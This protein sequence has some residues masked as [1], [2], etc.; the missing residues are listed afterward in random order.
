MTETRSALLVANAIY[1]DTALRQLRS[2]VTDAQALARVLADPD[3]GNCQTR[4]L[5]D[6]PSYE[7]AEE[8][9]TFYSDRK[10][11]E[12]LIL[13]FSCHGLKDESGRLYFAAS[14]T[15][16]THLMAT[17]LSSAFVHEQ[18]ERS[19][20]RRL[21]LLLDCCYSGAFGRLSTKSDRRVE[22]TERFGGYG[23]VIITASSAMEYAFENA[24]LAMEASE[25]SVFTN[26]MVRGLSTG[27]ADVDGDGHVSVDDLYNYVY[28]E[29]RRTTPNQTP[30]MVSNVQGELYIASS[31][32]GPI[33]ALTPTTD[34]SDQPRHRP[35]PRQ[36][37]RQLG[38]RI[39]QRWA[40]VHPSH[41]WLLLDLC[42]VLALAIGI[43]VL[44]SELHG[45]WVELPDLPTALEGAGV[46]S[47]HGRVWV[48][49]G[50]SP[51]EDRPLLSTV[52]VY[53]P[54]TKRWSIGPKLPR[55]VA[56]GALVAVRD[57]LYLI[58]GQGD[59]GAVAN[60]F[61]LDNPTGTWIEDVALPQPREAGSG[62]WDGSRII[63]AGGVGRDHLAKRDVFAYQDNR[64]QL[65]GELQLAR[66][67]TSAATDGFGTVWIIGGR[68]MRGPTPAYSVIDVI[69]AEQVR[70]GGQVQP[71]HSAAAVYWPGAGV[72]VVGGQ[73]PEGFTGEVQ[74][75]THGTNLPPLS[76]PRA[77]LGAAVLGPDVYVVGGYDA[78]HH[79]S[80][81][82]EMFHGAP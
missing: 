60:M 25:G 7:V 31:P 73:A 30:S 78:G 34:L 24:K 6:R 58:G 3:I 72:C 62:A 77:G 48:V 38:W 17:S 12:L 10:R 79:G 68:D 69:Q 1:S 61:R 57:Q 40:A 41:W 44:R 21:V 70:P 19:R 42:I 74:C 52:Q 35:T 14:N 53:D 26:V 32:A 23:R 15:K 55:P 71:I 81:T 2:P 9:E 4:L 63:Y 5:A 49:G 43:L 16:L 22:V 20:S 82:V 66:E 54:E 28:D 8:I 47:Y 36:W 39:A 64:W 27:A 76:H 65:V 75:L 18:M 50:V 37:R 29:V 13:Y 59:D 51:T 80:S 45:K 67:K 11:D 33:A 46:M 56:F